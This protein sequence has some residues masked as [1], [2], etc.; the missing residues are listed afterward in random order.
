MKKRNESRLKGVPTFHIHIPIKPKVIPIARFGASLESFVS[1]EYRVN[2]R[3][4]PSQDIL[5][6]PPPHVTRGGRQTTLVMS[7][8]WAIVQF[9]IGVD[10]I[11]HEETTSTSD[12]C[13]TI[14]G[15]LS[16]ILA[17]I[18]EKD[19]PFERKGYIVPATTT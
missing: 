12:I 15:N 16:S 1:R 19:V 2:G 11:C 6:T 10:S 13:K 8:S 18:T 17:K 9:K 14:G 5:P 7:L 4:S 3:L